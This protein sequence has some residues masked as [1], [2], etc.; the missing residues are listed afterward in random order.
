MSSKSVFHP[1]ELPKP[2]QNTNIH[3]LK[4]VKPSSKAASKPQARRLMNHCSD[5]RRDILAIYIHVPLNSRQRPNYRYTMASLVLYDVFPLCQA[6]LLQYGYTLY[7][8]LTPDQRPLNPDTSRTTV[9][10]AMVSAKRRSRKVL[11][12]QNL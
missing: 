2:S 10:G 3:Q 1:Q 6:C 4:Y 9:G 8:A 12:H 7:V 11:D 5:K